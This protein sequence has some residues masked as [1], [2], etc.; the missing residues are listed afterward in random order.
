LVKCPNAATKHHSEAA[1]SSQ[2]SEAQSS[3]QAITRRSRAS[4]A[5]EAAAARTA[6]STR[7]PLRN[8]TLSPT[9]RSTCDA[10]RAPRVIPNI[11]SPTSAS[12]T[13]PMMATV[14]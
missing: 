8:G 6:A 14:P 3:A 10:N 12:T 9:T 2:L 1:S 5:N 11:S 7:S 13:V 4:S